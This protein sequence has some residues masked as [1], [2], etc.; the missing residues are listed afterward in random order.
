MYENVEIQLKNW[1]SKEEFLPLELGGV[2]VIL[3]MQWLHSLGVTVV[4]WKNL[5]LTF[6]MD[7][8]LICVKGYPSLTKARISLKSMFKTWGDQDEGFLIECRAVEVCEKSEHSMTETLHFETS[9]VHTVLKQFE[10]VFEWLEKL[11][12]RR[13]IEHHI[14]LKDVP[15][16]S[17]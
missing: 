7:G 10:D 16:Q 1:S 6:T 15:T 14:H 2:D 11:P 17:M 8:K 13:E 3:G 9:P 12:P 4:D 5:T